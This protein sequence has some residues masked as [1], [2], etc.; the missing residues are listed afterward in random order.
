M[1]SEISVVWSE[2]VGLRLTEFKI[3]GEYRIFKI[4]SLDK[5]CPFTLSVYIK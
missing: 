3:L 1:G 5:K 4:A 2:N